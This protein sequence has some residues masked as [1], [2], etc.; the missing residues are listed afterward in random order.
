MHQKDDQAAV[1]A[2]SH[3]FRTCSWVLRAASLKRILRVE[4]CSSTLATRSVNRNSIA[5][6]CSNL[7]GMLI[8]DT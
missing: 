1:L 8:I 3:V 5:H 2:L 6:T 4:G 7:N